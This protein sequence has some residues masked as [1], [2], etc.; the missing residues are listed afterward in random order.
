MFTTRTIVIIVVVVSVIIA[1]AISLYFILKKPS[2]E[3]PENCK[4]DTDCNSNYTC[5]NN[6]CKPQPNDGVCTNDS[7]CNSKYI[8]KDSKCIPSDYCRVP[9]DC[10][11]SDVYDNTCINETCGKALPFGYYSSVV[12]KRT[13]KLNV[14]RNKNA[15]INLT[16]LMEDSPD[17]M[18]NIYNV[19]Y[20]FTCDPVLHR[21]LLKPEDTTVLTNFL[22]KSLLYFDHLFF[23]KTTNNNSFDITYNPMPTGD[24]LKI[25]F[26]KDI[27]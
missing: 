10:I 23:L 5:E 12:E 21:V 16:L 2:N 26:T 8:C 13:M 9:S 4:V 3:Q 19:K 11:T 25:T 15:Y 14:V 24:P 20:C 22:K 6:K 27:V 7:E 17:D 1:L 18:I